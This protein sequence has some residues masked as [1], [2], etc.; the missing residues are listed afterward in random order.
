MYKPVKQEIRF[1][2][3]IG[4]F[5]KLIGKAV[6]TLRNWEKKNVLIPAYRTKTGYRMYSEEQLIEVLQKEK[7]S[8]RINIGYC[9][10]SSNH[11]KDDLERQMS[12][13]ESYLSSQGR[14]FKVIQDVGS[15]ISYTKKGLKK[16]L[17]DVSI[18]IV[19]T[20]FVLHKDRLVR[21]GYELIENFCRLHGTKI[22]I[23]NQSEDKPAEEELVEDIMN[24][25]HVFS[26]RLNGRRSHINRKII[27]KL[28]KTSGKDNG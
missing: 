18:N 12:L 3:S 23:I 7:P 25:I 10:V 15:G 16:L 9:R 13:M 21:F 6:E 17:E 5:A 4:Q 8:E 22:D 11:Q 20:V 26:C 14:K 24:I 27:E 19:D 28:E 1:M 2:Y